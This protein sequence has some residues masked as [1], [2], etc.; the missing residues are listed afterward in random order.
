MNSPEEELFPPRAAPPA[1][2]PTFLYHG[3]LLERYGVTD[4]VRIFPRV[5]A[6][7]PGARL[8]LIG[9]G[10]ARPAVEAAID[11]FALHDSVEL[12]PGWLD[13]KSAAARV[14]LA[15]VGVV[16]SPPDVH[17]RFGLANK[18]MECIAVGVPVVCPDRPVI[19]AHFGDD[20]VVFYTAGDSTELTA[21]LVRAACRPEEM[22]ARARRAQARLARSYAWSRQKRELLDLLDE[23]ST[24]ARGTRRD[25]RPTA[26]EDS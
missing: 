10:D 26:I 18:M 21:A 25:G 24:A 1:G 12:S 4:L 11:E 20:E 13:L 19:R 3:S 17:N 15:H 14:P 16:A 23:Q 9:D 6:H 22:A 7:V 5:L 2:P 8:C